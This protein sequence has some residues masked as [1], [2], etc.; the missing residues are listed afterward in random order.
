MNKP[1]AWPAFRAYGEELRDVLNKVTD[2]KVSSV[3][4]VANKDAFMIVRSVTKER[5]YQSYVAQDS[6]S[7]LRSLLGKEDTRSIRV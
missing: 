5:R 1:K 4:R 2:W 6:P 7:W 3:K